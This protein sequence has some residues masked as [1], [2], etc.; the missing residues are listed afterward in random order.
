MG[1]GILLIVLASTL[2]LS[3]MTASETETEIETQLVR[4]EY[5]EKILARELAHSAFNLV[6]AN[7]TRDFTSFRESLSD[8]AYGDGMFAY[9]ATGDSQGPIVIEAFGMVGGT[10]HRID[11]VLEKSGDA[12]FDAI[13]IDGPFS[14]VTGIGNS[15]MISGLN[16]PVGDEEEVGVSADGHSIRTVLD[17]ARLQLLDE[18]DGDQLVG[19]QGDGD[20]VSGAPN[21]DLDALQ[22]SVLSHPDLVTLDGN[23]RFNGNTE[24][25]T[26][27]NPVLMSINGDVRINGSVSG[28]GVLFVNGSLQ[29][30]GTLQWEGLVIVSSVEGGV[31]LRGTVDLYGALVMRSLTTSGESGGYSDA[32]LMGGHFDVDSF[33]PLNDLVYHEHQYDDM[34]EVAELD[35][36]KSGCG[37][38]GGLC[39]TQNVVEPGYENIRL[40]LLGT[41]GIDGDLQFETPTLLVEGSISDGFSRETLTSDLLDFSLS[42]NSVCGIKGSAPESVR[43]DSLNRG[44]MLTL[45]VFDAD[46]PE[47]D[48]PIH[49]VSIYRHSDSSSCSGSEDPSPIDVQPQSLYING[50]V[51]IHRSESA[52]NNVVG[53]LP[54][55]EAP[56]V[57]IKL[58]SMRHESNVSEE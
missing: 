24:F 46:G 53:L 30:M 34:Y 33:G 38:D 4:T 32:G 41:A 17:E 16:V 25:G 1:R 42:F 6:V 5:Q 20:V 49:E 19:I 51:G 14:S 23:Q 29:A 57:E 28:F 9:S 12:L 22:D 39:W 45:Q 13:T 50:N 35:F 31:E 7:S 36:L 52:L 21:L 11:G 26:R 40:E 27:E 15:F 10:V 37:T 2:S 47:D 48:D 54:S 8:R 58:S 55:L 44:G 56:P 43:G 3:K 18:I